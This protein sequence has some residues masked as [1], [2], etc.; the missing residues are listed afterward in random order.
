M[1]TRIHITRPLKKSTTTTAVTLGDAILYSNNDQMQYK[2][3]SGNRTYWTVEKFYDIEYATAKRFEEPEL[4]TTYAK[5]ES[6]TDPKKVPKIMCYQV[7]YSYTEKCLYLDVY[8]PQV[9]KG[10]LPV[11]VY[12]HGGGLF[13]GSKHNYNFVHGLK[14]FTAEDVIVVAINYRL[15]VMGFWTNPADPKQGL[16]GLRDQITALRWVKAH[17]KRFGGDP[18]SVTIFGQSAGALSVTALY[19][20]PEAKGLFH[21]AIA[22]SPAWQWPGMYQASAE[23]AA[24][25]MS[26]ATTAA[27]GCGA[28]PDWSEL[29]EKKHSKYKYNASQSIAENVLACMQVLEGGDFNDKNK[30]LVG[31]WDIG[32]YYGYPAPATFLRGETKSTQYFN[33][34]DGKYLMQGLYKAACNGEQPTGSDVPLLIGSNKYEWTF[35][36]REG[37]RFQ[38]NTFFKA[39]ILDNVLRFR[40]GGYKEAEKDQKQCVMYKMIDSYGKK[41]SKTGR[42]LKTLSQLMT[43]TIMTIGPQLL[44]VANGKAKKYRYILDTAGTG[45]YSDATTNKEDSTH[46]DEL[47]YFHQE[48]MEHWYKEDGGYLP[49]TKLKEVFKPWIPGGCEAKAKPKAAK[50]LRQYWTTFAKTGVPTSKIAE[51][52]GVDEWKPVKAATRGIKNPGDMLGMPLMKLDLSDDGGDSEMTDATDEPW[53]TR[54]SAE[55]L[56][57]ISCSR[58]D[59]NH[60]A[61]IVTMTDFGNCAHH[62]DSDD[63]KDATDW[64]SHSCDQKHLLTEAVWNTAYP[65]KGVPNFDKRWEHCVEFGGKGE[66]NR[67]YS[68]RE[69][70]CACRTWQ[71]RPDGVTGPPSTT[72]T[73]TTTTPQTP[74]TRKPQEPVRATRSTNPTAAPTAA[75]P[76]PKHTAAAPTTA[77]PTTAAPTTADPFEAVSYYDFRCGSGY[78]WRWYGVSEEASSR[79]LT[80]AADATFG[81]CAS[82][83]DKLA[84]CTAYEWYKSTKSF[85]C[86][87]HT[88]TIAAEKQQKNSN[89]QQADWHTCVKVDSSCDS[90]CGCGW[91]SS[92]KKLYAKPGHYIEIKEHPEDPKIVRRDYPFDKYPYPIK[93][94]KVCRPGF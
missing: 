79:E 49:A 32:I 1:H 6:S 24:E 58:A 48:E 52:M 42:P 90:T 80:L 81:D 77:A 85:F 19:A 64:W 16:W 22:Q 45:G 47:C 37:Y 61:E 36:E 39:Q 57:Q 91:Y 27:V 74:A 35:F 86:Y 43:D 14:S 46:G 88:H 26:A 78:Q 76:K 12:L 63:C 5:E 50:M 56:A 8:R 55:L 51:A 21:K 92:D 53:T 69:K 18:D 89:K 2:E 31:L 17:I 93:S 41:T 66:N 23:E 38:G 44:S 83:C 28:K 13:V 87:L 11:M 4:K 20:S 60:S 29:K 71:T 33:G 70:C 59:S 62:D 73:P 84:G 94:A 7:P 34:F 54:E 9:R 10:L 67:G 25:S 82:K 75:T 40:V 72:A 65:I 30:R 15:N 3:E 68:Y